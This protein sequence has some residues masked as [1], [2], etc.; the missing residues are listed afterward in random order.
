M[1]LMVGT[2]VFDVDLKPMTAKDHQY[3]FGQNAGDGAFQAQA[4]LDAAMAFKPSS[5]LSTHRKL[6]ATVSAANK[7]TTRTKFLAR[8]ENPERA[9][10]ELEKVLHGMY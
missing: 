7:K 6:T 1:S 2:E 4:K 10:A 3:L 9:K 8:L 5:L